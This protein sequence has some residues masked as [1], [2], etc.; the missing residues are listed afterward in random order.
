MTSEA[1]PLHTRMGLSPPSLHRRRWLL[2]AITLHLLGLVAP[3][4]GY[5]GWY[6]PARQ[7]ISDRELEVIDALSPMCLEYE[8]L[9]QDKDFGESEQARRA[10][11]WVYRNRMRELSPRYAAWFSAI[12]GSEGAARVFAVWYGAGACVAFIGLVV[13]LVLGSGLPGFKSGAACGVVGVVWGG[14]VGA[15]ADSFPFEVT[16]LTALRPVLHL[17]GLTGG[18]MVFGATGLVLGWIAGH[19]ANRKSG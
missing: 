6:Q 12:I 11:A 14:G 16:F 18:A 8:G 13:I 1:A 4:V 17:S 7:K 2:G 10:E 5:L 3:L 15:L 9:S 19:V